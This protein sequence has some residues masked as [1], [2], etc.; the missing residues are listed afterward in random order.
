LGKPFI[1]QCEPRRGD[2][3][4]HTYAWRASLSSCWSAPEARCDLSPAREG[5][6]NHSY[7][8]ANPGGV[9]HCRIHTHGGHR[10]R[11]VGQRR[12]RGAILAQPVMAGKTIHITMRTPEG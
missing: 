9:T 5:W 10:Y 7:Y 3:L 11:V 12:R 2:T 8:N 6:E 4:S 1:L